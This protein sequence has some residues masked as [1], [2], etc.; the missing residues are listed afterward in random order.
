MEDFYVEDFYVMDLSFFNRFRYDFLNLFAFSISSAFVPS[1]FF[2]I[3]MLP[4]LVRTEQMNDSLRI[5]LFQ[6]SYFPFLTIEVG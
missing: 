5:N 4:L 6:K 2:I 3:A 1:V